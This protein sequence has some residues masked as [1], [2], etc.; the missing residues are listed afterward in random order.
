VNVGGQGL[1]LTPGLC[2]ATSSADAGP[3]HANPR[4]GSPRLGRGLCAED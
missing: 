3:G 1:D 4:C 2:M